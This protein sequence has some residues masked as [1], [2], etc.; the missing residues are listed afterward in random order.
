MLKSLNKIF[1]AQ[2]AI[3]ISRIITEEYATKSR[4]GAHNVGLDRDRGLNGGGT[5]AFFAASHVDEIAELLEE[6]SVK[7]IVV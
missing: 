4:K 6:K 1:H 5:R 2:N 7:S 3:N